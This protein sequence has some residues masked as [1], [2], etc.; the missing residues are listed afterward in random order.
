MEIRTFY[1]PFETNIENS[2]KYE[3]L[4]EVLSMPHYPDFGS[5]KIINDVI[6]VKF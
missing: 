1:P 4:P 6:V 2:E 5:I 3:S